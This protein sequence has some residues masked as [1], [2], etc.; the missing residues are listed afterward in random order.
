M[1]K[2]FK[3]Y[4]TTIV[5]AADRFLKKDKPTEQTFRDLFDSVCFR[6]EVSDTSKNGE[7]GLT[8][9]ASNVEILG[10]TSDTVG[11][12]AGETYAVDPSQLP[13][14]ID[15]T[16]ITIGT[17][18]QHVD[19]YM[20]YPINSNAP[21]ALPWG[22]WTSL[23][24]TPPAISPNGLSGIPPMYRVCLL[25]GDDSIVEIRGQV[26]FESGYQA[27]FN[28]ATGL[29]AP[30][31]NIYWS[32]AAFLGVGSNQFNNHEMIQV[33]FRLTPTGILSVHS[34]SG[35]TAYNWHFLIDKM[36]TSGT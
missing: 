19:G 34:A 3:A 15:G 20:Q 8:R 35:L 18:V 36:Y 25:D 1:A 22:V 31:H 33:I 12:Y 28:I 21:A 9:R 29:P 27:S 26:R 4:F 5:A 14:P 17:P 13:V 32:G 16:G 6:K 2:K 30:A 11:L 10:R 23:T 7:Q 24:L